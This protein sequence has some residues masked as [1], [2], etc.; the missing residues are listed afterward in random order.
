MRINLKVSRYD[1]Q[2]DGDARYQTYSLDLPHD[3][4]VLDALIQAHGYIDGSLALRYSCRSSVCG[5]CAMRID[6]QARLACKTKVVDLVRQEG[7]EVLVEPVGNMPTI[8]DLVADMESFWGKVRQVQPWLHPAGPEPEREYLVPHATMLDLAGVMNCIMCGACV[9]DCTVLEVDDKFIAP[10][11]LAK[12]YRF[13]GDPR[14]QADGDRLRALTEY[15]GVWDCTRCNMCVEVCPKG[16]APM[17]RILAL[18]RKAIEEGLQDHIA[19]RHVA[20]FEEQQRK[21]SW[22]GV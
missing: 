2:S 17:D 1:P 3:A 19:A 14:D 13:V 6:G 10:A 8:K 20:E 21:A 18:R 9:S 11:A 5:S 7:Q 22:M 16:V 4:T 12:A 15:G